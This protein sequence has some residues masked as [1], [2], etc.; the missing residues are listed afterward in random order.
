MNS[1]DEGKGCG[2]FVNDL[3]RTEFHK[4]VCSTYFIETYPALTLATTES[5]WPSSSRYAFCAPIA[6]PTAHTTLPSQ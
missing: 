4:Y 5:S 3:F 6:S 1:R 2:Q